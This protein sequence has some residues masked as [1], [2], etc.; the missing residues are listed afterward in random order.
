[1]KTKTS[2]YRKWK[3][4][5][6]AK[7]IPSSFRHEPSGSVVSFLEYL[8]EKGVTEGR[9][10]DIGCGTGRNS[11]FLAQNGFRVISFDYV[12]DAIQR[13][14]EIAEATNISVDAMCHDICNRWPI[15]DKCID[16][17]VDAFCFKHQI[18]EESVEYYIA[19]LCRVTRPGANFMLT[20]AGDDDGYYSQF[21][22]TSPEPQRKVIVDPGNDI[23]SVLYSRSD[24]EG[25]FS[26]TWTLE[27]Y[28]HK[29]K[30]SE[31]HG[32]KYHRSTHVFFF[33]RP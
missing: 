24:I 22:D 16:V 2:S 11:L 8:T 9:A 33:G 4:E 12:P 29:E 32:S 30:S 6:D 1:M 20:L 19:E 10:L 17:V 13:I 14:S 31:M 5:Y 27:R 3:E 26:P 28:E 15:D 7:G 25:L 23:A 18:P 21:L